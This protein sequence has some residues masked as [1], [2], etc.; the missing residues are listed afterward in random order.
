MSLVNYK[1]KKFDNSTHIGGWFIPKKLCDK[2]INFF[3]LN[4]NVSITGTVF[5]EKER[6]D[7]SIKDSFD[8]NIDFENHENIL[9]EYRSHL[10]NVLKLYLKKYVYSSEVEK[11]DIYTNYNLQKYPIKGGFKKW[12]CEN[13]GQQ[14]TIKRHLVFMTY[15]N[16]IEDGGTEFYYQKVKTKAEK[17]LTII[18]PAA[19][20]HT[21]KGSVS[22]TK[23]KYILT[24]WF[25]F[26]GENND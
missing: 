12:H 19:W 22:K 1:Q 23:E 7:K 17:G 13:N 21:H 9:G 16:D 10:D 2:F 8:L 3:E 18:W 25:S 26:K 20:T 4:K 6:I 11:F 5:N 14:S 24:G 15:L